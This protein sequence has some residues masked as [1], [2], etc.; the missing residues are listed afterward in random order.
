LPSSWRTHKPTGA[1]A[2][3]GCEEKEGHI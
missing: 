2:C 1:E 3:V